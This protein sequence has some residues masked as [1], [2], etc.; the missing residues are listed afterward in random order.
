MHPELIKAELKMRGTNPTDIARA[1]DV[2]QTAV[3]L[4]IHG[5]ATSERIAREVA[6]R[7]GVGVDQLWPGKYQIP[8]ASQAA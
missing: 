8:V 3:Y 5:S 2:T 6:G 7:I 4:V 1:L